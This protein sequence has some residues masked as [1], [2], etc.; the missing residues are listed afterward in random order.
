[1]SILISWFIALTVGWTWASV[2]RDVDAE[3][4]DPERTG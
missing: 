2:C 1:V 3:E 4:G